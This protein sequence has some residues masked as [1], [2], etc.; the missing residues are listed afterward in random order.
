[1]YKGLNMKHVP[2]HLNN[3]AIH[4]LHHFNLLWITHDGRLV[5]NVLD[6]HFPPLLDRNVLILCSDYVSM[7]TLNTLKFSKDSPL[8]FNTY[9]HIFLKKPLIMITKYL[10]PTI[11]VLMGTRILGCTISKGSIIWLFPRS[12]T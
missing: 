1:M 9:N 8:D 11:D 3:D 5:F 2:Y 7:N 6:M 12:E 4:M 10:A